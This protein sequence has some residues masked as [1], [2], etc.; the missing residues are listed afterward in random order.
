LERRFGLLLLLSD[1]DSPH[2]CQT[3]HFE[4]HTAVLHRDSL[5]LCASGL[6]IIYAFSADL[7]G[8]AANHDVNLNAYADDM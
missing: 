7:T 1:S 2:I 8:V 4:M 6:G 5:L 3:G